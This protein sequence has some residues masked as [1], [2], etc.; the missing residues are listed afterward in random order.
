MSAVVDTLQEKIRLYNEIKERVERL[1]E[2][3][4]KTQ[5]PMPEIRELIA[6]A[7]IILEKIRLERERRM[8]SP[9]ELK[10]EVFGDEESWSKDLQNGL[11]TG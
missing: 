3:E 9:D 11:E 1:K 7:V 10:E 4:D 2:M 6:L 5:L 8:L